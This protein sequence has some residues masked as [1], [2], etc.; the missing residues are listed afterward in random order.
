MTSRERVGERSHQRRSSADRPGGMK[1]SGIAS[2]AYRSLK[3]TVGIR[4]HPVQDVAVH[5]SH[6]RETRCGNASV[7]SVRAADWS[8]VFNDLRPETNGFEDSVRWNQRSA[9]AGT[10][11]REEADGSWVRSCGR[12]HHTYRMP[13]GGHYLTTARLR[14]GG[15]DPAVQPV[16]DPR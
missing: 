6:R 9:A 1:A 12:D 10:A 5:E 3:R 11:F 7:W 16:S 15:I 2:V 4:R 14:G 13:R 8:T